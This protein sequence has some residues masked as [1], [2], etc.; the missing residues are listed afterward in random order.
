M[1]ISKSD[2]SKKYEALLDVG[3]QE[4]AIDVL[5]EWVACPDSAYEES[6]A[7]T[8][9]S[10][11][12]D[13]LWWW[14]GEQR[15]PRAGQRIDVAAA[16]ALAEYAAEDIAYGFRHRQQLYPEHISKLDALW[17][18]YQRQVGWGTIAETNIRSDCDS[19]RQSK[20]ASNL[21][22]PDVTKEALEEFRESYIKKQKT[23]VWGWQ[24][25]ASRK[26]NVSTKTIRD[27]M[28]K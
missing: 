22:K 28:K 20:R 11:L 8:V 17:K 5:R 27:R 6:W 23:S 13:P 25:A 9:K 14:I 10:L 18:E 15:V 2:L 21:R 19:K 24:S 3:Y 12:I 1:N 16:M 7:G 26:F 4:H